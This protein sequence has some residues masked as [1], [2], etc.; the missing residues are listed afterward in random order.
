[1]VVLNQWVSTPGNQLR[2]AEMGLSGRTEEEA[3][4]ELRT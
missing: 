2:R 1:M 4:E 3:E